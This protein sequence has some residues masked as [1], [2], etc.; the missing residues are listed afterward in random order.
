MRALSITYL[1]Q[2]VVSESEAHDASFDG[3]GRLM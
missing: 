1:A 2:Y 3:R